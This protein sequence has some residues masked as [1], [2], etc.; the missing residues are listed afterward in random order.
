MVYGC[1]TLSFDKVFGR[2]DILIVEQLM[3]LAKLFF[4]PVT[5]QMIG[6]IE[7]DFPDRSLPQYVLRVLYLP[8]TLK[9]PPIPPQ[10]VKI[11][12]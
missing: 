8:L 4:W 9:Y 2:G 3:L 1:R 5:H 10:N 11:R 12:H 7:L 6:N